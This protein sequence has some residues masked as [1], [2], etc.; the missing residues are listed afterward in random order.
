MQDV[1]VRL[2]GEPQEEIKDHIRQWLFRVCR[3]RALDIQ[4]KGGRMKPLDETHAARVAVDAPGPQSVAESQD[5]HAQ[6]MH[7]MRAL[8]ENQQEVVRLKFQ[9]EMSYKEI[10]TVTELSVTNVGYLLHT[11]I[12]TLRASAMAA[13]E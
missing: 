7:L 10:A 9:N 13:G 1:F 6:I 11:A 12:N 5:S 4:R 8:P 3:N 2:W